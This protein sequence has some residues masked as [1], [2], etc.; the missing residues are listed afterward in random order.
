VTG[1][2]TEESLNDYDEGSEKEQ[3]QLSHIISKT[4]QTATSNSF[5]GLLMWSFPSTSTEQ[6]QQASSHVLL[7]AGRVLPAWISNSQVHT[8]IHL[9]Y[10][11]QNKTSVTFHRDLRV[12]TVPV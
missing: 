5:P 9:W 11:L 4:S 10:V 1:H 7:N 8:L 3:R 2:A 6:V 12:R